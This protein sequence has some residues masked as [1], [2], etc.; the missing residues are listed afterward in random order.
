MRRKQLRHVPPTPLPRPSELVLLCQDLGCR[1]NL[2]SIVRLAGCFGLRE[3]VASGP[4]GID[5]AIAREAADTV[6]VT[7]KR[8][9]ASPLRELALAGYRVV[10]LEQATGSVSLARHAFAP[11][12]ALVVGNERRG[13]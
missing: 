8:T 1:A 7:R 13:L 12:T 10:A 2:S 6:V 4:V 5:R 11:R 9:L 3:V